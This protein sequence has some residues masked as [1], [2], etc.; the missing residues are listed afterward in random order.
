MEISEPLLR[1]DTAAKH[2]YTP[3]CS[4]AQQRLPDKGPVVAIQRDATPSKAAPPL[5]TSGA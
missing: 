2:P 1:I 3:F 4:T 5:S